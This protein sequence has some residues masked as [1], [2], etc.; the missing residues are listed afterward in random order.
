MEQLFQEKFGRLDKHGSYESSKIFVTSIDSFSAHS[1][2]PE[3]DIN[4]KIFVDYMD[5]LGDDN[6]SVP[7]IFVLVHKSEKK[8][9]VET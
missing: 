9:N 7:V 1:F 2:I 8:S 3:S 4:D 6:L 5:S